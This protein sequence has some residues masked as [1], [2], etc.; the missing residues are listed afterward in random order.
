MFVGA[1]VAI[2]AFVGTFLINRAITKNSNTDSPLE[3]GIKAGE[4]KT[5]SSTDDTS[6]TTASTA[7]DVLL[8]ANS[9]LGKAADKIRLLETMIDYYYFEDVEDEKLQDGLYYGMVASLGDVYS[10]YF[11]EE[12]YAALMESSSGTYCGIGAT[13]SQNAATMI[14][15]VVKPFVDCPAYNAGMLPGDIITAVDGEDVVGQDINLVVSKMK[16]EAGTKVTVTVFRESIED[17]L[18][19]EITR[20]QIDVPTIEYEMLEDDIGYIQ[21][22]EFDEVTVPQYM[23]AIDDLEAKGMKGLIVDIRDNP[24]GLYDAVCKMLDRMLPEGTIIYTMDKYGNREDE[25]STADQEFNLPLAVLVN[26]SSA[27]ASEIFAAAIQDYN[28]GTI[29]GTQTFGK[30]IVQSVFPLGDGTAVKL[31]N[32]FYYTPKG[33]KI[34]GEG[35]TPDI[36]VELDEELRT[37]VVIEHDEDNQLKAAIED[38]KSRMR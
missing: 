14:L 33:R 27:S 9:M 2:L 29:I 6:S 35:I 30:G 23:A 21:I 11:N 28:K 25:Y 32:Y 26:G 37:K 12:E 18:D 10:T 16:G 38:V 13:V 34:H 17:Y 5:S 15:T 20:A 36:V 1:L 3:T 7:D 4:K 24:G 31:T 19:I 22:S 8:P